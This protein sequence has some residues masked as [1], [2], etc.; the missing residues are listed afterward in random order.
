MTRPGG[1]EVSA[2]SRGPRPSPATGGVALALVLVG[3]AACRSS[4]PGCQNATD[5][6][7][8]CYCPQGDSC[9]HQ[10]TTEPSCTLDCANGNPSCSATCRDNCSILCQGAGSCSGT[11]GAGCLVACQGAQSCVVS[12]GDGGDVRCELSG[13]CEVT[14]S[15]A[16]HVDCPEGGCRV[17][18]DDPARCDL[19]CGKEADA[20]GSL[21]PDGKT[22]TCDGGC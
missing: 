7:G 16:C 21:C 12:V 6:P 19:T 13:R 3:L 10:C 8:Y 18:C 22:K 4:E 11:C 1:A 17:S 20:G 9:E 15:G 5:A 2:V 14:C